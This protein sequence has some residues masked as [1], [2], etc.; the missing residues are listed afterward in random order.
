MCHVALLAN[1]ASV[2]TIF[3]FL[4]YESEHAHFLKK[5]INPSLNSVTM[6]SNPNGMHFAKQLH[7]YHD[8]RAYA[9]V[10]CFVVVHASDDSFLRRWGHRFFCD[11]ISVRQNL[12]PNNFWNK[13]KGPWGE[14]W[15][16]TGTRH[17]VQWGIIH[18]AGSSQVWSIH[19]YSKSDSVLLRMSV[20][21]LF[22]P[23]A[24][25]IA[26]VKAI[27]RTAYPL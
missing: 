8:G 12:M 17:H 5:L 18:V 4:R 24:R 20:A 1:W 16:Q 15:S 14:N 19:T 6:C 13:I 23:T 10:V 26:W 2:H 21:S 11:T 22:D 9:V 3:S 7:I 25:W 27:G